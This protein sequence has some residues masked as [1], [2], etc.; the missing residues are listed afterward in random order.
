M[1]YAVSKNRNKF[2]K[3]VKLHYWGG[4]FRPKCAIC[5]VK[6]EGKCR[7]KYKRDIREVA[8]K[9]KQN[10]SLSPLSWQP[11]LLCKC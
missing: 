10:Y 3:S 1:W 11:L 6:T 7:S 5:V 4:S 2:P 9:M 8:I